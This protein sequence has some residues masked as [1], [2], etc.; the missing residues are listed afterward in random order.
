MKAKV[1][2]QV[3]KVNRHLITLFKPFFFFFEEKRF[4]APVTFWSCTGSLVNITA[5][6]FD[7]EIYLTWR[8]SL[9]KQCREIKMFSVKWLNIEKPGD[10]HG[11]TLIEVNQIAR[12]ILVLRLC[13]LFF[14]TLVCETLISR[15]GEN[16]KN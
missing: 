10:C 15:F 13:Y 8:M 4:R 16:Q 2:I 7:K 9:Q 1:N 5:E 14:E 11:E 12:L 6:Y 3:L